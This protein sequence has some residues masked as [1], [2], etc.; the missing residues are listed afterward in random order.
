MCIR[1][2][3][4]LWHGNT[5]FNK[6]K[7]LTND[8]FKPK[9]KPGTKWTQISQY[10]ID[11]QQKANELEGYGLDKKQSKEFLNNDNKWLAKN[12][13]QFAVDYESAPM[14]TTFKYAMFGESASSAKDVM[15]QDL[16]KEDAAK[17]A[18]GGIKITPVTSGLSLIHI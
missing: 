15:Y 8:P 17:Y 5:Y 18:A 9:D 13:Y 2:R 14:D 11:Q 12:P 3:L 6:V 4:S 16:T 10:D 1:D 7:S